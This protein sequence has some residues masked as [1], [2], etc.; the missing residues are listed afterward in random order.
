MS[1]GNDSSHEQMLAILKK[2]QQNYN[3][4]DNFYASDACFGCMIPDAIH[5]FSTAQ[6]SK[7]EKLLGPMPDWQH[8]LADVL[9]RLE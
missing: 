6:V 7:T 3:H 8:N 5:A 4:F 9:R 1:C 2:Q